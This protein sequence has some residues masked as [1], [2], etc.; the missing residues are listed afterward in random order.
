MP[1]DDPNAPSVV[2]ERAKR[3]HTKNKNKIVSH[4]E[5]RH[6]RLFKLNKLERL[7]ENEEDWRDYIDR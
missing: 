2:V 3:E 5:L 4:D 7:E 1:I 6:A